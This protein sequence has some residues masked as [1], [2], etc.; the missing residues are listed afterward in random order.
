MT[1]EA[2]AAARRR[3]GQPRAAPPRLDSTS[4]TPELDLGTPGA[5]RRPSLLLVQRSVARAA[6]AQTATQR[7]SPVRCRTP[8]APLRSARACSAVGHAPPAQAWLAGHLARLRVAGLEVLVSPA[9]ASS[10]TNASRL[11]GRQLPDSP[12]SAACSPAP[13]RA[14]SAGDAAANPTQQVVLVATPGPG[15]SAPRPRRPQRRATRHSCCRRRRCTRR[16][17]CAAAS[18]ARERTCRRRRMGKRIGR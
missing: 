2:R 13:S 18:C 8:H 12:P 11:C 7:C 3:S 15:S 1:A 9:A 6:A 17:D 4:K 5:P 10:A 14:P 16:A